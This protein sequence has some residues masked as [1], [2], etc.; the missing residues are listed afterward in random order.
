MHAT[1]CIRCRHISFLKWLLGCLHSQ[2]F[3]I[4]GTYSIH[5]ALKE[6][7]TTLCQKWLL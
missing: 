5:C 7:D 4:G 6:L 2:T 1:V 3:K